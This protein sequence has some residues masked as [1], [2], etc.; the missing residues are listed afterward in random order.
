METFD[1]ELNVAV[2]SVH[3]ECSV[4]A[5][6]VDCAVRVKFAGSRSLEPIALQ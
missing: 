4:V 3:L 2:L 6:I 1:R 5:G